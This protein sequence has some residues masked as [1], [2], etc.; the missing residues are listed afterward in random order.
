MKLLLCT[1]HVVTCLLPPVGT[2]LMACVLAVAVNNA[3]MSITDLTISGA[4]VRYQKYEQLLAAMITACSLIFVSAIVRNVQVRIWFRRR[5]G[6]YLKTCCNKQQEKAQSS[7]TSTILAVTNDVACIL[8]ILAYASFLVSAI[9]RT[10]DRDPIHLI[11]SIMYFVLSIAYEIMQ[12]VLTGA[13]GDHYPIYVSIVQVLLVSVSTIAISIFA[14][15]GWLTDNR[16]TE[17]EW[18]ALACNLLFTAFFSVMFHLDSA[19]D[20]LVEFLCPC[21]IG[22]QGQPASAKGRGDEGASYRAMI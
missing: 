20:E 10:G 2:F 11:A 22:R 19:S 18:L 6:N 16:I 9:F 4:F 14:Y 21:C 7:R 1:V 17:A 12:T 15:T 3:D 5:Y 13:Q 8:N